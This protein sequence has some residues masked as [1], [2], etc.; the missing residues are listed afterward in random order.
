MNRHFIER[1]K[2]FGTDTFILH[3]NNGR[4]FSKAKKDCSSCLTPLQQCCMIRMSTLLKLV[5][6]Y[7]GPNSLSQ[8]MRDSLRDEPLSRVLMES[9]LNALD[10]RLGK[11]L[12]MVR[13]CLVGVK[14]MQNIVIN[15]VIR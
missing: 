2:E 5:K 8:V 9:H 14:F 1:F 10:R 4:G 13:N 7:L 6:L 15:D 12:K 3:N 11:I